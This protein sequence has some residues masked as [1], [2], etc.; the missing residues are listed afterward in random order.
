MNKLVIIG[1]GFDLAH[2]LKT[3][4]KDF[5]LWYLNKV[6][7][8]KNQSKEGS[9]I[10]L[11]WID[12][13][14]NNA[15]YNQNK[16]DYLVKVSSIEE[17]EQYKER[18]RLKASYISKDFVE[19]ILKKIELLKWVDIEKEYYDLLVKIYKPYEKYESYDTNELKNLNK[20]LYLI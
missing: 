7:S 4:Y 8:T 2:G 5:I 11:E 10:F 9:L 6:I 3:S 20:A 17:F 16:R 14:K 19:S 18:Y 1:N 15:I 13:N 12:P